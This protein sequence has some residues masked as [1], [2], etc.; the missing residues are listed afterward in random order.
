MAQPMR[1]PTYTISGS[2]NPQSGRCYPQINIFS[3][4]LVG[5]VAACQETAT[6][7]HDATVKTYQFFQNR[8]GFRGMNG[9]GLIEPKSFVWDEQ[10]ATL[11]C[12]LAIFENRIFWP[13]DDQSTTEKIL[14]HEWMHAIQFFRWQ[15]QLYCEPLS[16]AE[17]IATIFA[18]ACYRANHRSSIQDLSLWRIES[19]GIHLNIC[20]ARPLQTLPKHAIPSP[21]N[22]W[23]H[24][25][26]NSIL[27][28]YAFYRTVKSLY[29]AT[30][31]E[32]FSFNQPLNVVWKILPDL[33]YDES[34]RSFAMK[35]IILAATINEMVAGAFYEAFSH[36]GMV[37]I[38]LPSP[39][40]NDPM[41][42]DE[43]P[44]QQR[45]LRARPNPN[46]RR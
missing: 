46:I 21:E 35:S 44:P 34:L 23:G 7:L 42:V 22:D 17:A 5:D 26:S 32:I 6:K 33:A 20:P 4:A 45:W 1:W 29:R 2:Y 11:S 36:V 31:N 40:G 10:N 41:Q 43:P 25:H 27:V 28:S 14:A 39:I 9:R 12:S 8:F 38:P 18:V 19:L 24:V 16:L 3:R 30:R 13:I 15:H 37:E